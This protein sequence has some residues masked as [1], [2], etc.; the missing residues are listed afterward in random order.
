MELICSSNT[1]TG[2]EVDKKMCGRI[3]DQKVSE[4]IC[5]PY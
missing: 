2:A 3:L 5:S 4:G 1:V